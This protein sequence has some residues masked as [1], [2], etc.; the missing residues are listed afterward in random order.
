MS[1]PYVQPKFNELSFNCPYC[2][3]FARQYW[4]TVFFESNFTTEIRLSKCE[5]CKK[6]SIWNNK[7]MIFPDSI[8][9]NPPNEDLDKDI[10]EDYQEAATILSKSPRGA[11]ALL[12]LSVQKICKQLGEEGIDLNKDIANLVKKGLPDKVQQ[13]LDAVRVIGNEAVHPGQLDLKDNVSVAHRLFELINFIADK[14]VTQPKEIES[15]YNN[16]PKSK[17]EAIIDRD[18]K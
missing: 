7:K 18:K 4:D 2:G 6:I 8:S 3:A 9:V 10:R 15:I 12:R 16:I 5:H 17:K 11:A 13:A 1:V 14:M